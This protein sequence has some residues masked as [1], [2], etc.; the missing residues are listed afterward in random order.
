MTKDFFLGQLRLLLIGLLAFATGKGW[1]STADSTLAV[2]IITPLGLLCGPWIWSLYVNIGQKLV[3]KDSVAISGDTP[4][5]E[6]IGDDGKVHI[7]LADPSG[8]AK[9]VGS[10]L[11]AVLLSSW[12]ID[13]ASAQIKLT[14]NP[15]ADFSN[16]APKPAAPAVTGETKMDTAL[17][18]FG[19]GVRKIEKAVVDKG[20]DDLTAA[21]KDAEN[22]DDQI[23]LPCWRA[24]LKLLQSL[25][26]QWET[27]PTFPVGI[28]LGIQIQRDII[29]TVTGSDAGSIKVAC[30][31]LWGDQLKIVA[32]VAGLIGVRIATGGLF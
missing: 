19:D 1:L 13:P 8:A 16:L 26:S 20:I 7:K 27:P 2:S 6:M 32:N 3:P 17:Q 23:S 5:A 22:H 18:N 9:V 15:K 24:N 30:A 25:P 21:I 10:L 14:G 12:L 31:A 11:L 28:A 29:N 4:R